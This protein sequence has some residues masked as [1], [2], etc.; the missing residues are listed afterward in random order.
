MAWA[1]SGQGGTGIS[2]E[3]PVEK[4]GQETGHLEVMPSSDS[5]PGC[6]SQFPN[7]QGRRNKTRSEKALRLGIS[8]RIS[9]CPLD[10]SARED[11]RQGRGGV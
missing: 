9:F 2:G 5:Q 11:V 1:E 10:S 6:A 3:G 4:Q 7:I 8:E